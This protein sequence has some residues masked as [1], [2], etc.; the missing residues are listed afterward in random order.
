L[1]E[2]EYWPILNI[3]NDARICLDWFHNNKY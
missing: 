2:A 3:F 1:A